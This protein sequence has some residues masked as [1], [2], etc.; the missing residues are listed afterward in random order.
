[1][2]RVGRKSK[3]EEK[4]SYFLIHVLTANVGIP[5]HLLRSY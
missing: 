5:S 2:L 3:E 4:E 1:M